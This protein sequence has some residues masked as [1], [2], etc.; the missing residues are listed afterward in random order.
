[1]WKKLVAGSESWGERFESMVGF[2]RQPIAF[3]PVWNE[4]EL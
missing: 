3:E 4:T 2:D 1:M